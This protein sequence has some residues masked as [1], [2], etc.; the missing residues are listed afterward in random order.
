MPIRVR[1]HRNPYRPRC[2]DPS[3]HYL[4]PDFGPG[5]A[6]HH[7]GRGGVP[8]YMVHAKRRMQ[9]TAGQMGQRAQESGHKA[10]EAVRT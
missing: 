9:E 1:S 8:E 5:G 4:Q 2:L 7:R 10:Q 6:H 3:L